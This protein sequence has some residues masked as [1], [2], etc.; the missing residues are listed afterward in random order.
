MA[1]P[2]ASSCSGRAGRSSA[3]TTRRTSCPTANIC[4]CGRLL[5]AIGLSR[6]APGDIDFVAGPGP[7]HDRPAG[8]G[9][10]RLPALLRDHL[11]RRGGRPRA[12]GPTSSSTRRTTPGS[13]L[14]PAAASRP[15][16]AA[17][18]RGRDAGDPLDPDRDQRA[19][20]RRTARS[21]QSL[22]L[23]DGRRDRRRPAAARRAPTLV[24]P[25]R[26]RHPAGARLP[27]AHR[28]DCTRPPRSLQAR[29]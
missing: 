13:A 21:S 23:A 3:A 29:T 4:R 12:T 16:A 27:A 7:A 17:R 28:G 20:R 10:G 15:G 19:D 1:P 8:L 11:L 24:R 22:P 26:Q 6:L 18:R 5:S 9:Q 2:T 25:L 14:G